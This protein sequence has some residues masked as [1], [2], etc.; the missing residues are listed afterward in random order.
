MRTRKKLYVIISPGAVTTYRGY[1]VKQNDEH[2]DEGR[3]SVLWGLSVMSRQSY[4]S[5]VLS[6]EPLRR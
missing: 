5:F 6:I 2:Q 3:K 1:G 4:G